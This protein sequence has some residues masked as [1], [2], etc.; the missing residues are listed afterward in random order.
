MPWEIKTIHAEAGKKAVKNFICL[1]AKKK[2]ITA[3]G[4]NKLACYP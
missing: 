3:R 1:S 2:K 4:V